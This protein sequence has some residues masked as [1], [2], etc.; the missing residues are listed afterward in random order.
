MANP[1]ANQEKGFTIIETLIVL[2]IA[3]FILSVILLMVPTLQRNSRNNQRKQDVAQI[4]DAASRWGLNHSGEFPA[5]QDFLQFSDRTYY[6]N[7]AQIT[8][9]PNSA[10]ADKDPVTD[11][12][13]LKLYNY[14][15]CTAAGGSTA[16]GAGY[17]DVVALF[18]L[19]TRQTSAAPKCQKL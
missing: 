4:L 7:S 15:K 9:V 11:V 10:R 3:G 18:A 13:Q 5:N 1:A 2:A 12:D 14:A 17:D 8:I 6:T 16:T 19:E